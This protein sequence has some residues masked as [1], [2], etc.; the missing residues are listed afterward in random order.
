MA[1]IRFDDQGRRII[2]RGPGS[3]RRVPIPGDDINRNNEN[4]P[5]IDTWMAPRAQAMPGSDLDMIADSGEAFNHTYMDQVK[6]QYADPYAQ[7]TVG[8][9]KIGES[10]ALIDSL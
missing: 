1:G 6:T 3:G 2:P 9:R 7:L 4:R 5:S 8:E 10:L